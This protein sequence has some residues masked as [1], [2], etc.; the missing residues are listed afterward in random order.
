MP[1]A[2]DF[3]KSSSKA[4]ADMAMMG[5]ARQSSRSMARMA[6]VASSPSITGIMM[7][8]KITS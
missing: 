3:F 2:T 5:M 6:R 8:I 7:S 4:L 1:Q